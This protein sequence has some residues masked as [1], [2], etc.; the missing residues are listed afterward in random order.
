VSVN[1]IDQTINSR[2]N[3]KLFRQT[4]FITQPNVT[5]KESETN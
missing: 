2:N 5:I 1:A 3:P 4:Y